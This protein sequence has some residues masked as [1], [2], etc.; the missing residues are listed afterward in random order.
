MRFSGTW[1]RAGTTRSGIAYRLQPSVPRTSVTGSSP[2]LPTPMARSNGG[3]EVTGKG[4]TGGTMLAEHLLA[5]LPTP[6]ATPYG[7]NQ[8]PSEGAAVRPSLEGVLRL[9]P[10]PVEQ[11]GKN[12]TAPSQERRHSPGLPTTLRL[13]KT[14]TAAPHNQQGAN[15]GENRKELVDRLLSSGASTSLQ[16]DD[17]SGHLAGLLENPSFR[18]WLLGAPDGWSDPGC[19]LSAMEFK[20]SSA[21]SPANT[22]SAVSGSD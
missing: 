19:R 4:R 21:S 13:L 5:L 7:N 18:E 3:R 12:A 20:S 17:G 15:G 16:S 22:S 9:L 8:S 10:T 2:L 6:S 14:P 1:A 11:D